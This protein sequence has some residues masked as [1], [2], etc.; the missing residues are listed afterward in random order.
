MKLEVVII[1]GTGY[2]KKGTRSIYRRRFIGELTEQYFVDLF[3]K[4]CDAKYRNVQELGELKKI[5]FRVKNWKYS[6]ITVNLN[7]IVTVIN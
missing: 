3:N 5:T 4:M 2:Y 1:Y 7:G 6:G